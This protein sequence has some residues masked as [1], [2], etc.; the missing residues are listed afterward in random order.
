MKKELNTADFAATRHESLTQ[1]MRGGL[2]DVGVW[3]EAQI[4]QKGGESPQSAS[5]GPAQIA[6][7]A[8]HAEK[9]AAAGGD[10]KPTKPAPPPC[11]AKKKAFMEAHKHA[12]SCL[13]PEDLK[14]VC[15]PEAP[16]MMLH[17]LYIVMIV[18]AL[19]IGASVGRYSKMCK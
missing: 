12:A 2:K 8:A 9:P 19:V 18:L 10:K 16:D 13:T 15:A 7:R 4:D 3:R 11:E 17:M 1:Q 6:A 14:A 5:R